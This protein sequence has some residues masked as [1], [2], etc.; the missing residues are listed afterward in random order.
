M[1]IRDSLST[2]ILDQDDV[3]TVRD[4]APAYLIMIDSFVA[5]DPENE[6]LLLAAAQLY[7]AYAGAFVEDPARR[8]RLS[9]RAL[10]Y[11]RRGL[12]AR[13]A[14]LCES[15]DILAELLEWLDGTQCHRHKGKG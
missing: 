3:A 13:S 6:D 11:A 8:R 9:N 4:G 5:G 15:L 1:C 2:A 10:G 7:G 14:P 12:C